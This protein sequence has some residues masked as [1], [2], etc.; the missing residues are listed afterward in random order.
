MDGFEATKEIRRFNKDV[1]IIAQTNYA[2]LLEKC[3]EG[4]F[5]Y[6][7]RSPFSKEDLI[8]LIKKHVVIKLR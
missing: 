7:I 5:N 1:I 4:G 8:Q 2:N 3:L 6:Y